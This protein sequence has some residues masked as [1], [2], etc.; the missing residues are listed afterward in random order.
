MLVAIIM[1][2]ASF[3]NLHSCFSGLGIWFPGMVS[4]SSHSS[5]T[6]NT[7]GSNRNGGLTIGTGLDV[8]SG[9][10]SY[11][12]P[13][14]ISDAGIQP[15]E[16]GW[17][18]SVG[19]GKES[20][21]SSHVTTGLGAYGKGKSQGEM[22]VNSDVVSSNV[23][24]PLFRV[25]RGV[26]GKSVSGEVGVFGK[27]TDRVRFPIDVEDANSQTVENGV[28]GQQNS[29]FQLPTSFESVR[30]T[31]PPGGSSPP[32][33]F[34]G[35]GVDLVNSI[36]VEDGPGSLSSHYGKQGGWAHPWNDGKGNWY[37]TDYHWPYGYQDSWG[38]WTEPSWNQDG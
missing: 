17:R 9:S 22:N 5:E 38:S 32:G 7:L 28:H 29:T 11:Q 26:Y 27:Q 21:F 36:D 24:D 31:D 23:R 34:Y 1:L 33:Y 3:T 25:N 8:A 10:V 16:K 20:E 19:S 15:K 13:S 2:A 37:S 4:D 6:R 30:V 18:T 12:A 35:Y 14:G